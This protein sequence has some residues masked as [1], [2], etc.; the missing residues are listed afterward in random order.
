MRMIKIVAV[1]AFLTLTGCATVQ[2]QQHDLASAST[3]LTNSFSEMQALPMAEE[4]ELSIQLGKESPIFMFEEGKSYYAT[5]AI[6][7]S[8]SSRILHIKTFFSTSYL[9]QANIL[10]PYFF[11]LNESKQPI[12]SEKAIYL[13]S[14][15][16]F[17]QGPFYEGNIE[18]PAMVKEIVI[19]T[20]VT[21]FP[22]LRSFSGN[23]T[24]RIVPHAPSGKIT[25]SLSAPYPSDY[26]FSKAIIKDTVHSIGS[27]ECELFF[28][29]HIDGKQIE[30]S[31]TKTLLLNSGH[32]LSMTPYTVERE[33]S[34]N[35]ATYTIVGRTEYAAPILALTNPVYE[36]KG[37][38]QVSLEKDKIYEVH[39]KLGED[40]SA[41]WLE[42][43]TDHKVVGEKIE[44][45]GSA[46]LGILSK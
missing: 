40:Y 30:D 16:D 13:Q 25:L 45:H 23:G 46:K 26:D 38:V 44:V 9:P 11:F 41:V 22:A 21:Q 18:V 7:D 10:Y 32:G 39:G 33:V 8:K 42:D 24:V 35:N 27:K 5:I 3:A 31:R 1:V 6:P 4:K 37:Q 36:V 19:Y 29:S 12:K 28:V 2:E 17:L 20:A 14:G 15:L 34:V 43:V